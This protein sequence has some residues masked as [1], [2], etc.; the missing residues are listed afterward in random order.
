MF[1]MASDLII[2]KEEWF[3]VL[4]DYLAYVLLYISGPTAHTSFLKKT[5]FGVIQVIALKIAVLNCN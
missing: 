3:L 2:I 1:L 5:F 4:F